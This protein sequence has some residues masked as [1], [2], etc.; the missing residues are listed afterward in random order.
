MNRLNITCT[1]PQKGKRTG[2]VSLFPFLHT[3]YAY[4]STHIQT[5][6]KQSR[7]SNEPSALRQ[8]Y[9]AHRL[10]GMSAL[11]GFSTLNNPD[12]APVKNLVGFPA[13]NS[14]HTSSFCSF[15]PE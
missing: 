8:P 12:Y 7:P 14:A 9:T 11:V 1:P 15:K 4:F 2:A 10:I 13:S 6:S 3:P 5:N